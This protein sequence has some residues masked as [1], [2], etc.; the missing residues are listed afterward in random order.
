M[1][2]AD[3]LTPLRV[4]TDREGTSG[5]LQGQICQVSICEDYITVGTSDFIDKF[6]WGRHLACLEVSEYASARAL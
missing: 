4:A 2:Q 6:R 5:L 1:V 3:E